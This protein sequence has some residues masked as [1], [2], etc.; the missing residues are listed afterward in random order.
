ML[1][2]V[3]MCRWST[4]C[5]VLVGGKLC[6]VVS[7]CCWC[8]CFVVVAVC[9]DFNDMDIQSGR[10]DINWLPSRG[11]RLLETRLSAHARISHHIDS[12]STAQTL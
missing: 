5:H 1:T 8:C 10:G 2:C 12:R 11:S 6:G 3:E 7:G 9:L 4:V